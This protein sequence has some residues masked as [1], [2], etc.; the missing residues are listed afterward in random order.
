MTSDYKG[1]WPLGLEPH[2]KAY[3]VVVE[4]EDRLHFLLL[5]RDFFGEWFASIHTGYGEVLMLKIW[6]VVTTVAADC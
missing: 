4:G 2:L 1:L 6:K 5:H 3:V